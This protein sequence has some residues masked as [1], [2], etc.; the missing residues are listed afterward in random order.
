M[1]FKSKAGLTRWNVKV[2]HLQSAS[3][4]LLLLMQV[5]AEL[6]LVR[7]WKLVSSSTL[8]HLLQVS[9]RYH[10]TQNFHKWVCWCPLYLRWYK[11]FSLLT[12]FEFHRAEEH[13]D[14]LSFAYVQV[15]F[16]R[17]IIWQIHAQYLE[18]QTKENCTID[19]LEAGLE[20]QCQLMLLCLL[21]SKKCHWKQCRG[22][23]YIWI[24]DQ[25]GIDSMVDLATFQN[26][27][28]VFN[29]VRQVKLWTKHGD[30]MI[31]AIYMNLIEYLE[32][33]SQGFSA[34]GKALW[35]Q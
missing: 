24:R 15:E 6:W 2:S 14:K 17:W 11:P 13:E 1:L 21:L 22:S 20:M 3:L 27:D 19:R 26:L 5:Q 16:R 9:P 32:L 34:R 35:P 10:F 4:L 28:S 25:F 23:I 18:V 12:S 30:E 29:N 8:P 33:L 31:S 7:V